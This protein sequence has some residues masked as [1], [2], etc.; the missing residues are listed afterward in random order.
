[1]QKKISNANEVGIANLFA[2]CAGTSLNER[3]A[4]CA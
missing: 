2:C 1:M 4:L 3:V